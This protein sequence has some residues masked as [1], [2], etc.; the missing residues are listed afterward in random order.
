META[1][2]INENLRR[3]VCVRYVRGCNMQLGITICLS[4]ARFKSSDWGIRQHT[5]KDSTRI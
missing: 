2:G 1:W 4:Q 3:R 5:F